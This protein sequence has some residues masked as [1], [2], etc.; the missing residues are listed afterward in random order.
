M[1]SFFIIAVHGNVTQVQSPLEIVSG[2]PTG[3]GFRVI[4]RRSAATW[5]QCPLQ[6]SK[7]G[8]KI[9]DIRVVADLGQSVTLRRVH[10][11][12]GS[13]DLVFRADDLNLKG[14]IDSI[15]G[16]PGDPELKAGVN[17]SLFVV[18]DGSGND[19]DRRA[20]IRSLDSQLETTDSKIGGP[21]PE[22]ASRRLSTM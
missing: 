11:W 20:V 1:P 14:E 3:A 2:V 22:K 16:I 8:D 13:R 21:P 5:L 19:S 18:F 10:V 17:V 4:G 15:F 7:L 9:T 12:I 6:V